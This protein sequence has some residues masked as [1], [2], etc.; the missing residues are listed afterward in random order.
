MTEIN[1]YT[2]IANPL[3]ATAKLIA[4]AYA[5]GKRVR[6]VTPDESTTQKL[7]RLLWE[8]PEDSFVPHVTFAS[9]H[10]AVTPIIVDHVATHEG[11]ADVLINLSSQPPTFFARF[12]RVFEIVG[13]DDALAT[14]GRERWAFYKARG[15]AMT[16]TVM[17]QR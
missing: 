14:A 9:K 3:A 13:Q 1:F 5:S 10:A 4:K 17:N 12:E 7:D 6:V 15:Y 8:S 16:H 11:A 2:G